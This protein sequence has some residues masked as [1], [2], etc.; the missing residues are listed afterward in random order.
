[1]RKTEKLAMFIQLITTNLKNRKRTKNYGCL[2]V[3]F[4][5]LT[6]N[7][8][9]FAQ[10]HPEIDSLKALYKN[11]TADTLKIQLLRKIG[12]QYEMRDFDSALYFYNKGIEIAE[13]KNLRIEK[14]KTIINIGFAYLYGKRSETS[15]DY[16]LKGLE[17]YQTV[18]DKKGEMDTYYNLGTFAGTFEHFA[19]AIRYFEEAVILGEELQ[20]TIRLAMIYNNLG[21]M[22]QYAGIHDKAVENQL[23]ALKMKEAVNDKTTYITRINIGVNY[24]S[25]KQSE[26]AI[27]HYQ[28][29]LSLLEQQEF[30]NPKAKALCYNGI[31]EA[32]QNNNEMEKAVSFFEKAYHLYSKNRDKNGMARYFM[33]IGNIYLEKNKLDSAAQALQNAMDEYPETGGSKKLKAS[34]LAS[35]ANLELK[36]SE[37]NNNKRRQHLDKSITYALEMK[38]IAGELGSI[39]LINESTELLYKSYK[40]RGNTEKAMQFVEIF[41]NTKDTIYNRQKLK[42]INELQIRYE[43]QQKEQQIKHLDAKQKLNAANA[44]RNFWIAVLVSAVAAVI[45]ILLIVMV[46]SRMKIR[47][48]NK[49]I[50]TQYSILKKSNIKLQQLSEFKRDMTAMLVHDL[51]NPL[52]VILN[53]SNQKGN[54]K[55]VES[56]NRPAYQMLSLV[57]NILDTQKLEETKLK[58]EIT[59]FSI[60]KAF[61]N[62]RK[63]LQ[64]LA[65]EKEIEL[66]NN[67][68]AGVFVK[69]DQ[70]LTVRIF[71]NLLSNAI[72][73]TPVNGTVTA[74]A[75][76]GDVNSGKSG[77][78]RVEIT[79]TGSGIPQNEIEHI[80]EKYYQV[81]NRSFGAI[82]SSGIGLAFCKLAIE[83]Q[84]GKIGVD[85]NEGKGCTFWFTLPVAEVSTTPVDDAVTNDKQGEGKK[86]VQV[87]TALT[88]EEKEM[89]KDALIKLQNTDL[90]YFTEIKKVLAD[91]KNHPN[92]N[93]KKWCDEVTK[94]VMQFNDKKYKELIS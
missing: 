24:N 87:Q 47:K 13:A 49:Q 89:I 21:L 38:N 6:L 88:P 3:L 25:Q 17:V 57:S 80:F 75:V 28:K 32:Y 73:H 15:I 30:D 26:K 58:P 70:W 84:S 8:S 59:T 5:L 20:D 31:G 10:T 18:G 86:G 7:H 85:C 72:K 36:L 33:R 1:M 14:A 77:F 56:I 45:L 53:R 82:R 68:P 46:R 44:K 39:S 19:D 91:L 66:I 69:A 55:S 16:L 74:N 83:I 60:R 54:E 42:T 2:F 94:A 22:Y 76:I 40:L 78:L 61:K 52:N 9:L 62:S 50:D 90:N 43:T 34:L 11:A 63:N 65:N 64:L 93:I 29:A 4:L 27:E 35:M 79:D 37:Q 71:E 41:I 51:K 48:K 12:I 92:K 23:N 81:E 67:I